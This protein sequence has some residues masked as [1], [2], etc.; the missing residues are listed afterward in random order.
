MGINSEKLLSLVASS[1]S[2]TLEFKESFG[3]EVVID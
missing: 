3:D 1:E 2:E